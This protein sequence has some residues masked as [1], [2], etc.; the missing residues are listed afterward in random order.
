MPPWCFPL[1]G[2]ELWWPSSTAT[3]SGGTLWP[4]AFVR[5]SQSMRRA[6]CHKHRCPSPTKQPGLLS[7]GSSPWLR[8]RLPVKSTPA[9]GP[10]LSFRAAR[11]RPRW[12]MQRPAAPLWRTWGTPPSCSWPAA[13]STSGRWTT[14]WTRRR[15]AGSWPLAA[16]CKHSLSAASPRAACA[17]GA[18]SFQGLPWHVRWVISWPTSWACHQSLRFAPVCPSRRAR[19]WSSHQTAS[20]RRCRQ[21]KRPI[22]LP[23]PGSRGQLPGG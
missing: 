23:A 14:P 11:P 5:S 19:S 6:S 21:N 1:A 10:S 3:G 13:R 4:H 7:R 9:A 17:C 15:S 20:G 2:Q 16:R 22:A 18:P 8:R 12:W